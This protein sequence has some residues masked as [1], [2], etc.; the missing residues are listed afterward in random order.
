MTGCERVLGTTVD[1]E[2]FP[3]T[4]D[5]RRFFAKV[6][7]RGDCWFWTGSRHPRGY[8][9]FRLAGRTQRAH[10]VIFDWFYG[11]DI[12]VGLDIDHLC[13]NTSCVNPIH[14]EA[15]THAENVR[16]G[17]VGKYPYGH[18]THCDHGH[19][20]TPENTRQRS[21][22]NGRVCLTCAREADRRHKQSKKVSA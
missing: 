8:G 18:R 5:E 17:D 10:R 6:E 7:R 11:P 14:L 22:C 13:R 1:P 4:P 12:A 16:R 2:G 19:E 20:F 15:V 9:G 3:E 21:D